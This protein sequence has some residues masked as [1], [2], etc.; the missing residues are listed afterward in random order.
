MDGMMI[1]FLSFFGGVPL[2][3]NDTHIIGVQR[4]FAILEKK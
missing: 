4:T 1:G 2:D 3:R